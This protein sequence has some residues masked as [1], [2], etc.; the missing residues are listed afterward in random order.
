M[1]PSVAASI[2]RPFL[3]QYCKTIIGRGNVDSDQDMIDE[4]YR[5]FV[6]NG[7][8]VQ[9]RAFSFGSPSAGGSNYGNGQILRL[10]KDDRNY[11]IENQYIDAKR[12]LCVADYQTGTA[13]GAEVFQL[14]GQTP[15]RDDLQRSGSGAEA[16]LTAKTADDSL[17]LNAS[18]TSFGGSA[19]SPE[20]ISSWT[21]SVTVSSTNYSFDSSNIFR[22]APSDGSTGYALNVKASANLTQKLSV[23][24]TKLRTDVPYILAVAWNRAVGSASGTLVLRMGGVFTSVSVAAQTGWVVTTVP[25]TLGQSCWYR[26]FAEDDMD[27]EI[28]WTRT[29]GSL[30]IDDVLLVEGTQ[31]DNSWYWAI[32]SSTATWKP[33]RVN[34][35]FTW[36][37]SATDSKIQRWIWRAFNRYLPH[38]LGSS[39]SFADP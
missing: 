2:Q 16:T 17:L 30:L 5:Y 24:G 4:L 28:Q 1:S 14:V 39:I 9:S 34:D 21:S 10:N 13:R 33:H 7:L 31:F 22:L 35:S 11:D 19:S 23:K 37:N 6:D 18:W 32:P 8:R 26:L 25:G 3:K 36:A 12:A 38:S 20:S 29:S 27:I 15:A